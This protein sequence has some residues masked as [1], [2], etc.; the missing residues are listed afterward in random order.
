MEWFI[1]T[2]LANSLNLYLAAEILFW[3]A[4]I[5]LFFC[6]SSVDIRFLFIERSPSIIIYFLFFLLFFG[7][8]ERWITLHLFCQLLNSKK[9]MSKQI[10]IFNCQSIFYGTYQVET[11]HPRAQS[12]SQFFIFF[13][14]VAP[15]LNVLTL[16]AAAISLSLFSP[17]EFAPPCFCLGI[18]HI[19]FGIGIDCMHLMFFFASFLNRCGHCKSLAPEVL[20]F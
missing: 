1:W 6:W 17:P 18:L 15:L 16:V 4:S 5:W 11:F 3:Y 19:K 2:T 7:W 13:D 10:S 8:L 20:F 9:F 12:L 14:I